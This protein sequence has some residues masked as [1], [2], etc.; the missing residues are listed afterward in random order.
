[1]CLIEDDANGMLGLLITLI[2]KEASVA[3][4]NNKPSCSP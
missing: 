3:K 1:V 2:K 4:A